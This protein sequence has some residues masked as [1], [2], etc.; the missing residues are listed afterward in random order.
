MG[1]NE[2][3]QQKDSL[4]PEDKDAEKKLKQ[5]IIENPSEIASFL[6]DI[7]YYLFISFFIIIFNKNNKDYLKQNISATDRGPT[8]GQ[9]PGVI[10]ELK[11]GESCEQ[12]NLGAV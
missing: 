1:P 12:I 3:Q 4:R 10:L 11:G 9:T 7:V 2:S 6:Q 8:N 5:F